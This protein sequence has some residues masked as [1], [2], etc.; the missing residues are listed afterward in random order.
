MNGRQIVTTIGWIWV[1]IGGFLFV[2]GAGGLLFSTL[3]D[4]PAPPWAVQSVLMDFLW[5]HDRGIAAIQIVV[6]VV[7]IFTAFML[8]RRH[9]W[10]RL[11]IQVFSALYLA[12]IVY[13][14]VYCLS[15]MAALTANVGPELFMVMVRAVVS[16]GVVVALTPWAFAFGLSLWALGRASVR[17]EF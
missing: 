13:F 14:G 6:A 12:W 11:G 16:V 5:E 7:V 1:A 17:A 2:G 15:V 10:A 4:L 3:S 9:S 8:L